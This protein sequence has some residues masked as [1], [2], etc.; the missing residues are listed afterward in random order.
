MLPSFV[1][2]TH[3]LLPDRAKR[4]NIFKIAEFVEGD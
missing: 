4:R 1:G 3:R 2:V